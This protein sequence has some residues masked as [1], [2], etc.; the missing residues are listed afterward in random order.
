MLIAVWV[1]DNIKT[2]KLLTIYHRISSDSYCYQIT[3]KLKKLLDSK[4]VKNISMIT[5]L[6][7]FVFYI[8]IRLTRLLENGASNVKLDIDKRFCAESTNLD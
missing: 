1:F 7:F 4:D 2:Y 5:T 6:I 8:Y 3:N